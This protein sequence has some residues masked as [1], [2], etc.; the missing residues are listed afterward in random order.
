MHIDST[1]FHS[2][3]RGQLVITTPKRSVRISIGP[4][5]PN[6]F[7][8]EMSLCEAQ[9]VQFNGRG[10]GA[11]LLAVWEFVCCVELLLLLH[12]LS[13][14]ASPLP[15]TLATI[16]VLSFLLEDPEL[17][18]YFSNCWDGGSISKQ[19]PECNPGYCLGNDQ[20]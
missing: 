6:H 8:M 10:L 9:T 11:A 3:V 4:Y 13:W 1:C 12:H 17:N 14:N 7:Q 18:L 19:Y 2:T 20:T 5:K 16:G 15:A